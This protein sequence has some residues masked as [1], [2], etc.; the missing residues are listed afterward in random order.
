MICI[1]C[2]H[3]LADGE[4]SCSRCG[5]ARQGVP[6]NVEALLIFFESYDFASV[7]SMMASRK[8]AARVRHRRDWQRELA[9]RPANWKDRRFTRQTERA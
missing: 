8:R 5:R 3:V 7:E 9:A 2:A 4:R 6:V 1:E